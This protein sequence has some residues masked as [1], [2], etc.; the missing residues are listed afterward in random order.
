MCG[1]VSLTWRISHSLALHENPPK[2]TK[3]KNTGI[4]M[5]CKAHQRNET[6]ATITP[7]KRKHTEVDAQ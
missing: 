1:P 5:T 6:N 7:V 4:Q 3:N 2:K